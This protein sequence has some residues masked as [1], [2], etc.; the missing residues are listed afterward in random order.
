MAHSRHEKRSRRVVFAKAALAA[1]ALVIVLAA[2]YMGG[3]L[4]EEKKYPE[5]RGEM[6]AGFGEVP[7]VEIDGVTY[8][9]KMDVTSLLMIGTDKASTD[10]IKGYR[11]G[12][13]SDFLL[14]LVLDHKN[15]TIRQL[16]IDRDTMT[17][18]NVLGLFGNNAGSRVM[19]ICLSHGYGMDRQERCQNSLRAV[20][21]LLN[22]P[23]IELY[24][25]VPLDA[26]STLNDL[27]G[28][29][30][31]TLE[32]DF[33]AAD[34][35]MTKGATLTLTGEQAVTLVRRR[36]DVADGTNETRMTRQREFMDAAVPLIREK[37]NESNGFI[38]TMIDTLTPYVTTNMVRGR[39]I[40]EINRAYHYEG[41]TRS[42]SV[43]RT[44]HRRG[45][46]C[47]VPCG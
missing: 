38:T 47:G 19:Q 2:G 44:Q 45:W 11:D 37:I 36:M 23:E 6:S 26:I 3:R 32:D 43:R 15:K 7:K 31:V 41:G 1:A 29:V 9:Q 40:N 30:T 12:G 5:I 34:P 14:L 16:Q 35:A 8:E 25:E 33:T 22:C 18:V 42:I 39:M 10:E 20:E 27:L 46:I 24:M 4:L 17:S 21:G 13:Q 28:G